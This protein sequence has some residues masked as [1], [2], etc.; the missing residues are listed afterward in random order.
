MI[1]ASTTRWGWGGEGAG[2]NSPNSPPVPRFQMQIPRGEMDGLRPLL[3]SP[4]L[5][6]FLRRTRWARSCQEGGGGGVRGGARAGVRACRLSGFPARSPRWG[7]GRCRSLSG[8]PGRPRTALSA[9]ARRRPASPPRRPP[10]A[11]ARPRRPVS[12]SPALALSPSLR[13]RAPEP[14]VAAGGGGG[15]GAPAAGAGTTQPAPGVRRRGL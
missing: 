10:A 6:I 14:P 12:S 2:K 5:S 9:G 15:P 11:P 1:T 4:L 3:L 7:C 13:T 8:S